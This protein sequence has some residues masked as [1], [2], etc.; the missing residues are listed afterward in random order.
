MRRIII[1]NHATLKVFTFN[2]VCSLLLSLFSCDS[3]LEIDAS[4]NI[5]GDI[6]NSSENIQAALYAAYYNLGGIYDG[7]DGGEIFG[8]DFFIIPTLLVAQNRSEIS[9]DATDAGS[10]LD[11]IDKSIIKT[12]Q[13]VQ[14]NWR[15]CYETINL[16][17]N[18][19]L[20]I[21]NVTS[22]KDRIEG[23]ALGMRALLYFEMVRLWGTE[24]DASSINSV[25]L[26]LILKPINDVS[27]IQTPELATIQ[28]IY[29][30]SEIDL[31]NACSLLK[32]FGK[33]GTNISFYTCQA[34]L[35]RLY[36]HKQEYELAKFA[37]DSILDGT[38]KL[39]D[40]PL[41]AFNNRENSSEDIF[42][43]QQTITDN[44]G[45]IN[46]ATGITYL[47]SSLPGYGLGIVRLNQGLFLQD[48]LLLNRPNFE[49]NDLRGIFDNNL[50]N[51]FYTLDSI[52][53]MFFRNLLGSSSFSTSK[54]LNSDRVMPVIRLAEIYLARAECIYQITQNVTQE[55]LDDY[56][57]TRLRAGLVALNTSDFNDPLIFFESLKLEKKR[58]FLYEGLIFHD[59]KRWGDDIGS[60]SSRTPAT[61]PKFILPIPQSETDTWK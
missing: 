1:S 48:T 33:N 45:D 12:N 19:L 34:Y 5:S 56:N 30:Q 28:A 53:T 36:M 41:E 50:E 52:S 18:I 6:Y 54:F 10:Y 20:N 8:G 29:D 37:A 44:S 9:L 31:K 43:I 35:M 21:E 11:F 13:R 4:K 17:N 22:E 2:V 24:Y 27:E 39:A 26:P 23:E 14:A 32:S 40:S 60:Y 47:T 61:D 55:S 58:E 49:E 25:A 3:M 46:S 38:F 59:L 57:K 7:G 15:R 42:A 16:L 51:E